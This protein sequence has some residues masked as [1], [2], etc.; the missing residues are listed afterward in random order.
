[1]EKWDMTCYPAKDNMYMLKVWYA[2][3]LVIV[4][5]WF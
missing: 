3:L 5:K 2:V 4:Q 1:M